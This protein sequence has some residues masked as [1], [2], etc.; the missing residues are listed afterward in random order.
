MQLG[1]NILAKVRGKKGLFVIPNRKRPHAVGV[2][3]EIPVGS[4]VNEI[5]QGGVGIARFGRPGGKA[6]D[7]DQLRCHVDIEIAGAR[8][9]A[10]LLR[11]IQ[12]ASSSLVG[13][14]Q[15]LKLPA[16]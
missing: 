15:S 3:P 4:A 14:R 5:V 8:R 16:A 9:L 6:G 1:I 2:R 7:L 10:G 11:F 13:S 12:P